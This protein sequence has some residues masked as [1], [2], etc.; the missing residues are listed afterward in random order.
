MNSRSTFLYILGLLFLVL[1]THAQVQTG[2][3]NLLENHLGRIQNRKIGLIAN[4]TSRDALGNPI[5]ELLSEHA[6]VVSAFGLEHGFQGNREAGEKF[7]HETAKEIKYFSLY[8]KNREPSP[9]MLEGIDL[10]VY[11]VQDVGVRFYT[12]ISSLYYVMKAAKGAGIP[13]LV[14]DRPNPINAE[15]VEGPVLDPRYSSFV[16]VLPIPIRYGMTVGELARMMNHESFASE[17]IH[18]DLQVIPMIGYRRSM[19]Y[20]ETGLPWVPTSPNIPTLDTALIYPG[21]CL[22]EGTNLSEGRGTES[23]F[24]TLGAP[25]INAK[26]WLEKIP[27]ES[28]PGVKVE[29]V[30]F[31]P[32]SIPGKAA[33]PKYMNET[34]QGLAFEITDRH[35]FQPIELAVS[36]LNAAQKLYPQRFETTNFLNSLWGNNRLRSTLQQD[37][38]IRRLLMNSYAEHQDFLDRREK[39]LLY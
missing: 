37:G 26:Q 38:E 22:I 25:Y 4:Q 15:R 11:D 7:G 14:L 30:S 13:I 31:T 10:L 28:L 20:D 23:P 5:L 35:K 29:V 36:L 17:P 19:Y 32:V 34:C 8:G 2:L 33:Q 27:K 39:Y 3:E 12:Y 9:E 18:A 1:E 24:L 6:E 16:G 21:T